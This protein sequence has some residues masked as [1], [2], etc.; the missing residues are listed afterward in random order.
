MFALVGCNK[1]NIV[2]PTQ[3][4]NLPDLNALQSLQQNQKHL[5]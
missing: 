4:F 2:I 3:T 5:L 1:D